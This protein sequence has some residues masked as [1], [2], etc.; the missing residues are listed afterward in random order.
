MHSIENEL[1]HRKTKRAKKLL[2]KIQN[3]ITQIS[4]TNTHSPSDVKLTFSGTW[5]KGVHLDKELKNAINPYGDECQSIEFIF[6]P[7]TKIILEAGVRIL[8]L[9]N[10][11]V[12]IGKEVRLNFTSGEATISYLNRM[13]FFKL[14]SE[15]VTVFSYRPS[16]QIKGRGESLVEL[17]EISVGQNIDDLP[18][19][20]NKI[21]RN[22]ANVEE[23]ST[24]DAASYTVFGEMI[25][26]IQKH[27]KRKLAGYAALQFYALRGS[28]RVYLPQLT[29][30][31]NDNISK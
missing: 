15:E 31:K 25:R 28:D 27:S 26:N 3:L 24:L 6:H 18:I 13:D 11:L 1:S 16:K 21:F 30:S 14:L 19:E 23:N 29:E 9:C 17:G 8:C 22:K 20:L 12:D 7:D 2:S 5:I 10:Q 4:H